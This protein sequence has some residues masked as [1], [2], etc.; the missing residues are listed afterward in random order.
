MT[1]LERWRGLWRRLHAKGDADAIFATLSAGYAE[2]SRAYHTLAHVEACLTELD[3]ARQLSA[4]PE[5][6]EFALWFHDAVY[7]THRLDN[8]ELSAQLAAETAANIGLRPNFAARVAELI[9]ATKHE[10]MPSDID[11]Q[12]VVDCDLASLACTPEDFDRNGRLVRRECAW[13][14]DDEFIRQ[15]N[16]LFDRFLHRPTIYC[17]EFFRSRYET[18]A[19]RNLERVRRLPCAK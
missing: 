6:V 16:L 9:V 11:A 10:V 14:P 19:R 2:P 18:Q 1:P 4:N 7:D 3:A 17:T 13:M 15:R 12:L 5:Q 8:E